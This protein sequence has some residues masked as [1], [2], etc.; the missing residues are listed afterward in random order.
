MKPAI[1]WFGS[2]TRI[3][4]KIA[5]LFPP[6]RLYIE[7][8]AGSLAVLFAKPP[9]EIEVVNDKHHDL[10]N[11]YRVMR[12]EPDEFL[13]RIQLTPFARQEML[14]GYRPD[15]NLPPVERAVRFFAY[16]WQNH[17][18]AGGRSSIS[19]FTIDSPN[20]YSHKVDQ[21]VAA[22]NRLPE[23]MARLWKVIIENRDAIELIGIYGR[24]DSTLIYADPPYLRGEHAERGKWDK[25]RHEFEDDDH[26]RLAEALRAV[27]AKCVVS[28]YSDPRLAELYPNWHQI[29]IAG[30]RRN[31]ISNKTTPAPEI[32]LTNFDPIQNAPLFAKETQCAV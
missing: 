21:Y 32:V 6:H 22:K 25:Y 24:H 17:A 2:K 20:S 3:A 23:Q 4:P 15:P 14:D 18:S 12:A 9:S 26:T 27:P 7:A 16:P 29:P 19:G 13:R 10:V 28:Y 30:A 5:A 1:R 8:F 11:L 31:T